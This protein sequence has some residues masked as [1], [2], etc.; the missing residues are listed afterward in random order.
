MNHT[1]TSLDANEIDLQ[2]AASTMGIA[3]PLMYL[4]L[5]ETDSYR[6][7]V[8]AYLRED[9]TLPSQAIAFRKSDDEPTEVS[10]VRMT[11]RLDG[12][13][14]MEY[15][16]FEGGKFRQRT[17]ELLRERVV[18]SDIPV[19]VQRPPAHSF[20]KFVQKFANSILDGE[21]SASYEAE[22]PGINASSSR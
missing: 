11:I 12:P 3:V 1:Y 17:E 10:D 15:A 14:T 8:G 4:I 9:G 7:W 20:R 5:A 21:I 13:S 22:H 6:F 18:R 16:V 19:K 2:E